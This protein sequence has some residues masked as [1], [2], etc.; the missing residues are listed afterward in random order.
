MLR[1]SKRSGHKGDEGVVRDPKVAK[2]K[3]ALRLAKQRLLNKRKRCANC[4]H[5]AGLA[6]TGKH[7]RKHEIFTCQL[8]KST[9]G[10]H[11]RND[12]KAGCTIN[13]EWA[14]EVRIFLERLQRGSWKA[15][16]VP[17]IIRRSPT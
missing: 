11:V 8:A 17:L 15:R 16:R 5:G 12:A 1:V 3:G 4:K 13:E 7:G 10:S 6:G 9:N 2:P 14:N